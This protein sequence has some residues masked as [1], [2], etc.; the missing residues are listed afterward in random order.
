MKIP[1]LPEAKVRELL[2]GLVPEYPCGILAVRG[3]YRDTMGR[4]GVQ[5][6]GIYDDAAFFVHPGGMIATQWNTDPS[7]IGWN[8]GVG[9]NFAMLCPGDW[10]FI[11][12]AHK[13]KIPAL[14][15]ADE[16]QAEASGIPDN[17][18]FKVWRAKS[19]ADVLSGTARTEEG[20]FAINCHRGGDATTSSWGCQTEPAEGY[21]RFL[22][23]VWDE[24]KECGMKKIPYRLMNGPVN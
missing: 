7:R 15:Q 23:K 12:G 11:R 19:M 24:T 17:G 3:Y 13:G 16:D 2:K 4:E 14:R 1:Q 21:P 6:V 9:K 20:Y 8:P 18:H 22:Q 5:E 10:F